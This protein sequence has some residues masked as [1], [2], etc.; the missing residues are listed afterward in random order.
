MEGCVQRG[1]AKL[2]LDLSMYQA[3]S[4]IAPK[5][6]LAKLLP[7]N[8]ILPRYPQSSPSL[9]HENRAF[10]K[11]PF[12][13]SRECLRLWYT[14]R[15]LSHSTSLS[16]HSVRDMLLLSRLPSLLFLA[17]S[18]VSGCVYT[19][20]RIC[21]ISR[22]WHF[23]ALENIVAIRSGIRNQTFVNRHIALSRLSLC[24]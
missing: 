11:S 24:V 12:A 23:V 13:L 18:P 6:L 17:T 10:P 2:P 16:L 14:P 7:W 1:E 22:F 15:L 9:R 21:S 3:E 4:L 20:L 19:L 5:A 8:V